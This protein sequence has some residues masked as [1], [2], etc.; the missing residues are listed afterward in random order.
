MRA[1][2]RMPQAYHE[3]AALAGCAA[4]RTLRRC[5]GTPIPPSLLLELELALAATE[6]PAAKQRLR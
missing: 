4:P 5:A 2:W 1:L 3:R 6:F